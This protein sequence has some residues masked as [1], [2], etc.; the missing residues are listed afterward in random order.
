MVMGCVSEAPVPL[1]EIVSGA[2]VTTDASVVGKA[3]GNAVPFAF[4]PGPGAGGAVVDETTDV[5]S[6]GKRAGGLA[7][8]AGEPVAAAIGE[9]SG[10]LGGASAARFAFSIA[11]CCSLTCCCNVFTVSVS[12]CTCWRSAST[13]AALAGVAFETVGAGDE[14]RT[15]VASCAE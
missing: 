1:L 6:V 15:G 12:D 4:T 13:S 10:F 3:P 2:D 9:G 7:A 11:A 8:G 14:V 5:S